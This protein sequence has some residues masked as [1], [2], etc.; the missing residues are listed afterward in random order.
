MDKTGRCVRNREPS[1][2]LMFLTNVEREKVPRNSS[3]QV[4]GI[5][6][7]IWTDIKTQN[8]ELDKNFISKEKDNT[9]KFGSL[10]CCV[11][12]NS[13]NFR[14]WILD[15]FLDE[16]A[17][18]VGCSICT[19]R[20]I[21]Q[22]HIYRNF[23]RDILCVIILQRSGFSDIILSL[24]L[25]HLSNVQNCTWVWRLCRF[26]SLAKLRSYFAI[27]MA[28]AEF[29]RQFSRSPTN[30]SWYEYKDTKHLSLNG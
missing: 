7:C 12:G 30:T 24:D 27:R 13:Q 20:G 2:S 29:T 9:N 15:E 21:V 6:N 17:G 1:K 23:S 16:A 8:F 5:E 10:L 28:K 18:S 22:C 4:G 19:E 26:C 3:K 11:L 25:Y 14:C